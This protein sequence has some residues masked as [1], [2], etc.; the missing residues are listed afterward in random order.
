MM[1]NSR[2]VRTLLVGIA[3]AL[4]LFMGVGYASFQE[5]MK[6]TGTVNAGDTWKMMY[7]TIQVEL[8][9]G[10]KAISHQAMLD[11]SKKTAIFDITLNQPGDTI[12]YILT[13]VNKGNIDAI[14]ESIEVIEDSED[15]VVTVSPILYTVE[16]LSSGAMIPAGTKANFTVSEEYK[17]NE[18]ANYLPQRKKVSVIVH[19]QMRTK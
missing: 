12:S 19:Y 17:K 5:D 4:L 15:E 6:E 1:R 13:V 14:V 10:S 7:D 16:G 18:D 3:C 8:K 9:E 2:N 11:A